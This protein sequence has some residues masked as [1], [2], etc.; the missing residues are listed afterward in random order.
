MA[1]AGA[2][3][4]ICEIAPAGDEP[5]RQIGDWCEQIQHA[6]SVIERLVHDLLDFGSFENGQLRVRAERHD[7][8]V[9][10]RSA[11]EVIQS[12]AR[13]KKISLGADFPTGAIMAAYDR[14]RLLQVLSNLIHNAI[15]FTPEGGSICVRVAR[16]GTDVLVSVADTGAGIPQAELTAIFERFRRLGETRRKGLG[17]GLYIAKWIVEAHG[18]RIWVESQLGC[19]STFYV[20]LPGC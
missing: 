4:L 12:A 7:V 8:T 3:E 1:I 13:A 16:S 17:L 2:A 14:H 15:T 18:G 6:A 5:G 11:I 20:T 10:V 19:G 9:L